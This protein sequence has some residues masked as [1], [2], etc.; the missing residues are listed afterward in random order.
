MTIK[1]E[2]KDSFFGQD[3][4]SDP[5]AVEHKVEWEGTDSSWDEHMVNFLTFL[6]MCGY[7]IEYSWIEK[8]QDTA[9]ELYNPPKIVAKKRSKK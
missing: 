5:I 2:F 8:L 4:L 6:S 9:K 1:V 7:V 3:F